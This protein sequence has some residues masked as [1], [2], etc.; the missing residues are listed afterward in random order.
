MG[1]APRWR[2][3]I[4][5]AALAAAMISMADVPLLYAAAD[6]LAASI[7]HAAR[8][9]AR[10]GRHEPDGAPPAMH[11][12]PDAAATTAVEKRGASWAEKTAWAY[13]LVGGS[14]FIVTSPGEKN[15]DGSWSRDGKAE[16]AAG[17][18][19]V[20]I[21]FALLRDILRR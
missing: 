1:F 16:M 8:E 5:V 20:G 21:S 9:A 19:A 15:A 3:A 18:G 12:Q 7:A 2:R 14:V 11:R 13:L 17:I 6:P 4:A 10:A